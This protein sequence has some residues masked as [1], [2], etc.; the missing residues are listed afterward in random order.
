MPF[1]SIDIDKLIEQKNNIYDIVSEESEESEDDIVIENN[2]LPPEAIVDNPPLPYIEKKGTYSIE[3]LKEI[4]N[5][6]L[7]HYKRQT[8]LQRLKEDGSKTTVIE[9][10][11]IIWYEYKIEEIHLKKIDPLLIIDVKT[12]VEY[13]DKIMDKD[14]I[15]H[16]LYMI[17]NRPYEIRK[18]FT[19]CVSDMYLEKYKKEDKVYKMLQ[20]GFNN[21]QQEGKITQLNE[22]R[23]QLLSKYI[24]TEGVIS[25]Y[26]ESP[27]IRVIES[28][29]KCD[30]CNRLYTQKGGRKPM[31][32]LNKECTS[33]SFT[34]EHGT[35]KSD[36]FMYIR[37]TQQ[38]NG[39]AKNNTIDRYI[40]ISGTALVNYTLNNISPGQVAI[41]NGVVVLEEKLNP[42]DSED[43]ADIE[44]DAFSIEQKNNI[45]VFEYDER[46]LNIVKDYINDSNIHLHYEKL[47]R[48]ICAHLY[49]QDVLKEAILLLLVGTNPRIRP[50]GTRIKGDINVLALGDPGVG[51]SDASIFILAASPESMIAGTKGSTSVTG[52]TS[53]VGTNPKTG[54]SN[55]SVGILGL[56]DRRG[57]AIIEEFNRR[58][59]SDLFE[60]SSATDDNQVIL[61][62]KGG[63]HSIIYSR[64]PIYATANSLHNNGVWDDSQTVSKQTGIDAFILS[65]MDLILVTRLEKDKIYKKKLMTHI[66]NQYSKTVIE[67]EYEVSMNNKNN[68]KRTEEI[69]K[70]VEVSLRRNDFS[71]IY[72]IEYIRHELFYL[73]TIDCKLQQDSEAYRKL[74]DYWVDFSNSVS[75]M[76]DNNEQTIDV[77][78]IRK[79]ISL[80]KMTEAYGRIFRCTTPKPE[81]AQMAIELMSKSLASQMPKIGDISIEE[82]NEYARKMMDRQTAKRIAL[83]MTREKQKIRND[84][85]IS[86]SKELLRFNSVLYKMGHILCKQCHGTGEV[87]ELIDSENNRTEINGCI[88]CDGKGGFDRGFFYNDFEAN[89]V[90][91]K[92]LSAQRC[93]NYFKMYVDKKFIYSKKDQWYH[94]INLNSPDVIDA[95]RT[96][97]ENI[98]DAYMEKLDNEEQIKSM[99][100]KLKD[101]EPPKPKK[102]DDSTSQ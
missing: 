15:S 102:L 73:K 87:S 89:I 64:C 71:G 25:Q 61:V 53:F 91:N 42:K 74:E 47:K 2:P 44:I 50:D 3:Y 31:K 22:L 68:I 4:V 21:F 41:I 83:T 59:K 13:Q 97:A 33:R 94:A 18:I 66:K 65:R 16:I 77:M 49:K 12:L 17:G 81:H 78:D 67:K 55:I 58:N 11:D 51:K 99:N 90:N 57:V 52:L 69:L 9:S 76:V 20:I 45:N 46:L 88:S 101:G 75:S 54:K 7:K 70:G 92:I 84:K 26:D 24:T 95:V 79:F 60:F 30:D 1:E 62:N 82:Q 100:K 85:Y 28:V 6:F 34:Q 56:V 80:Q 98:A 39:L 8:F 40:K 35:N 93:M 48:S 38:F 32:C 96:I 10:V 37:V 23:S 29:W 19:E 27:H 5:D 43:I 14:S 86:F 72:P 63:F 36:D